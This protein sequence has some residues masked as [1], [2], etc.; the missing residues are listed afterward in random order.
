MTQ[1]REKERKRRHYG[2]VYVTN[3]ETGK[4]EEWERAERYVEVKEGAIIIERPGTGVT[5]VLPLS[6]YKVKFEES[7]GGCFITT[8]CIEAKNLPD[9]CAELNILRKFRDEFIRTLPYGEQLIREYYEI[10]PLI[11][12]AIDSMYLLNK[13][14]IL[15]MIT[16]NKLC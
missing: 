7:R 9:Y 2:R 13:R 4:T 11:V 12:A 8:A 16:G 5:T 10:A 14:W 6:K 3:L 15:K 1:E